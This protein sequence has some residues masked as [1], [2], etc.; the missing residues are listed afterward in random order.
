LN[1]F[2][3]ATSIKVLEDVVY[4]GSLGSRVCR[5]LLENRVDVSFNWIG[6]DGKRLKSAGGS[7]QYLRSRELGLNYIEDLFKD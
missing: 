4:S 5:F 3:R 7:E 1:L 2:Q 6:I